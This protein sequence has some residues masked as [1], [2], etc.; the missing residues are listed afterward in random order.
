MSERP[1]AVHEDPPLSPDPSEEVRDAKYI[2][3][4]RLYLVT[5]GW[6]SAPGE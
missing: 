1:V 6:V 4:W 5:L 3:G 2:Q